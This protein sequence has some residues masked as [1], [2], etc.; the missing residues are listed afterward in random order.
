MDNGFEPDMFQE[1]ERA[2]SAWNA[3]VSGARPDVSGAVTHTC[4]TLEHVLRVIDEQRAL[5]GSLLVART[6]MEAMDQEPAER[7]QAVQ[8]TLDTFNELDRLFV[9]FQL[10]LRTLLAQMERS[11]TAGEQ[12]SEQLDALQPDRDRQPAPPRPEPPETETP[13]PPEDTGLRTELD[14]AHQRIAELETAAAPANETPAQEGALATGTSALRQE[15]RAVRHELGEARMELEQMQQG[16]PPVPPEV[17]AELARLRTELAELR[18]EQTAPTT[19]REPQAPEATLPKELSP[20]DENGNKRRIGEMLVSAGIITE[21]QL[22]EALE[23]QQSSWN[24]H[25]GAILVDRGYATEE[26][27][28][29]ALARQTGCAFIDL[30]SAVIEPLALRFVSSHL[31]RHH[32]CIPVSLKGDVL[33][34]AM[35]NPLDLIALDDLRLTTN[36]HVNPVVATASAINAA[37]RRHYLLS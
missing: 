21:R 4:E 16:P 7:E 25:L 5:S 15:L 12:L 23:Q 33:T 9:N 28:A 8:R 2:V 29:Q 27:I 31:A 11:V 37:I 17:Q 18:K 35:A 10:E 34:V 32:T 19:T 1:L 6:K 36:R 24:R 30:R 22:I 14:A 20:V 13:P 26:T 3:K